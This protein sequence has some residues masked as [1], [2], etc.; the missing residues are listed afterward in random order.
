MALCGS[1]FKVDPRLNS[2]LL[3]RYLDDSWPL[4][5][6]VHAIHWYRECLLHFSTRNSKSG[7]V[8]GVWNDSQQ[9][10]ASLMPKYKY[11]TSCVWYSCPATQSKWLQIPPSMAWCQVGLLMIGQIFASSGEL[12][13][14]IARASHEV[15]DWAIT[16]CRAIHGYDGYDSS[17]TVEWSK[18]VHIL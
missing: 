11:R 13:W 6:W 5:N 10:H 4:K 16:H 7:L 12:E 8:Q 1:S 14:P 3:D 18:R 9:V 15:V 2:K 17:S